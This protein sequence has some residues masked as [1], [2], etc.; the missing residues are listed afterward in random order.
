MIAS[1]VISSLILI[2][3]IAKYANFHI[4]AEKKAA[5][6]LER[7][8]KKI[9]IKN[10]VCKRGENRE[11]QIKL[12]LR[13]FIN[14]LKG[15]HNVDLIREILSSESVMEMFLYK[16]KVFIINSQND[17]VHKDGKIGKFN[18]RENYIFAGLKKISHESTPELERFIFGRL[19]LPT[20]YGSMK[21]KEKAYLSV[22]LAIKLGDRQTKTPK[23]EL[24]DFIIDEI[25][26]TDK[27]VSKLKK[28]AQIVFEGIMKIA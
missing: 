25:F 2:F 6:K 21:R 7:I 16:Y 3:I 5:K 19:L 17:I 20:L 9:K 24:I 28:E 18:K 23:R 12:I 26:F 4:S 11:R 27:D 22:A 15:S 8:I 13:P 1:V 14:P 10:I